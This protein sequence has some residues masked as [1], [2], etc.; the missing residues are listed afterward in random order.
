MAP[1]YDNNENTGPTSPT[2]GNP[3]DIT[4]HST[5]DKITQDKVNQ[6]INVLEDLLNH[7]HIF[8]D[9]YGTACN[10]NCNCNCTRGSL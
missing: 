2:K 5:G 3:P 4:T 9:D 1:R 10:C 7:T 8:Y 6:M